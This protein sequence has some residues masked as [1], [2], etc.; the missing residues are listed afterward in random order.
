MGLDPAGP[1]TVTAAQ[2]A[3]DLCA[4]CKQL[5]QLL[6][7]LFLFLGNMSKGQLIPSQNTVAIWS[8]GQALC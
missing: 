7:I 5:F 6:F 2:G 3:Q 1:A 4:L 8:S